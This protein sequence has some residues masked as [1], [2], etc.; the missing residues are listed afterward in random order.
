MFPPARTVQTVCRGCNLY[1]Y[2]WCQQGTTGSW[3]LFEC[4]YGK[5][6]Q[7]R[8]ILENF[9]VARRYKSFSEA[10]ENSKILKLILKTYNRYLYILNFFANI[11]RQ[12]KYIPIFH[13]LLKVIPDVKSFS[14]DYSQSP[15]A[16]LNLFRFPA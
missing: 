13:I 11:I 2:F 5:L 9:N 7:A 15:T 10:L 12:L 16:N 6:L 14:P 4:D 8:K 3:K 1:W